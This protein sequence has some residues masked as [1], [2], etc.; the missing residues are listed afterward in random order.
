MSCIHKVYI[1]FLYMCV[2]VFSLDAGYFQTC[3]TG[4]KKKSCDKGCNSRDPD[5]RKYRSFAA[6]S[7]SS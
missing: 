3:S 2:K 5:V 7:H 6:R 4:F 1:Y